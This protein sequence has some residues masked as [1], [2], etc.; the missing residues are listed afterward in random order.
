MIG[1]DGK[2]NDDGIEN[3]WKKNF[4]RGAAGLFAVFL[5]FPE[6]IEVAE[7]SDEAHGEARPGAE[8]C[9]CDS[10]GE[11]GDAA[12]DDNLMFAFGEVGEAEQ[13]VGNGCKNLGKDVFESHY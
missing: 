9:E 2:C 8:E 12:I 10:V 4:A 13:N 7:E 3:G 1:Q 6:Q 11:D 5:F